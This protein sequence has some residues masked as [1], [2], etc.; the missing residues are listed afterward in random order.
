[1]SDEATPTQISW[2]LDDW[3]AALG[4]PFS[5][6]TF[7]TH[8]A[9]GRIKIRKAGHNLLIET[10]PAEFLAS[11]PSTLGGSPRSKRSAAS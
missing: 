6:P 4:H 9:N 5:K 7:Y 2:R 1:M 11:C 3:M 8:V 10:S